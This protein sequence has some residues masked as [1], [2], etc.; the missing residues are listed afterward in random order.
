[1]KFS[2]GEYITIISNCYLIEELKQIEELFDE[3]V[4]N[5][6]TFEKTVIYNRIQKRKLQIT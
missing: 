1:M 6:S 3:E 5:Y 2:V 4:D